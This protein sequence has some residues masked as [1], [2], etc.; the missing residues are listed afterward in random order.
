[1][2]GFEL[3]RIIGRDGGSLTGVGLGLHVY[4]LRGLSLNVGARQSAFQRMGSYETG[5][6]FGP[7]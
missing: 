3:Y 7:S 4:M 2:G 5:L 1:M 6:S